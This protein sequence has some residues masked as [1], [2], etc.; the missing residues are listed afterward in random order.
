MIDL[1]NEFRKAFNGDPWHGENV[2]YLL[3]SVNPDKAFS[4]PIPGAHSI[5][6]LVLHLTAWTEETAD[7][8]SGKAAKMPERGDWPDQGVQ[9]HASW[10]V[11]L[12][13]FMIS[14]ERLAAICSEYKESD[15]NNPVKDNRDPELGTGVNYAELLNGVVQHHAYH[16]GQIALLLKY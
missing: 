16:A 8:L 2:L 14:N 4:H 5:A 11:I 13:D 9:E 3:S 6:E 12:D 15:W 7:R 10:N 1:V